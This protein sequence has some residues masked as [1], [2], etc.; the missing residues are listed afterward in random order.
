MHCRVR[1]VKGRPL[2]SDDWITD[3]GARAPATMAGGSSSTALPAD[4]I[5]ARSTL[6]G[7]HLAEYV[8]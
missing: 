5:A 7:Q 1:V 4:L 8:R 6:T 3:P 2:A